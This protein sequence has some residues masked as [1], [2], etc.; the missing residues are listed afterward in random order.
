MAL[1]L[2]QRQLIHSIKVLFP[3]LAIVLT[4]ALLIVTCINL[5]SCVYLLYKE[6]TSFPTFKRSFLSRKTAVVLLSPLTLSK[7]NALSLLASQIFTGKSKIMGMQWSYSLQKNFIIISVITT[8]VE[9]ATQLSV[10][11]YVR[12]SLSQWTILNTIKAA[13]LF[14]SFILILLLNIYRARYEFQRDVN[15]GVVTKNTSAS[16]ESRVKSI[17]TNPLSASTSSHHSRNSSKDVEMSTIQE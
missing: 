13:T 14:L 5:I 7:A 12:T 9:D 11:F 15:T 8:L 10:L 17:I 4:S 1:G 3:I 2:L 16:I 6:V